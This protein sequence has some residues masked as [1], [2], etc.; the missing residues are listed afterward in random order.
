MTISGF[1]SMYD[2]TVIIQEWY[3]NPEGEMEEYHNVTN[4]RLDGAELLKVI[5]DDIAEADEVTFGDNVIE[6]NSNYKYTGEMNSVTYIIKE[7][8]RESER[9]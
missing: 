3:L 1:Y 6:I 5:G 9:D 7:V 2:V 4:R 8:K